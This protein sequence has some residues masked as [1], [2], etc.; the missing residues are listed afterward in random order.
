MHKTIQTSVSFYLENRLIPN[1]DLSTPFMG[2]PGCG[3]TEFL[4]AALPFYLS[5]HLSH[6]YNFSLL[7]NHCARLPQSIESIPVTN[8]L[9]A[10]SVSSF[11]NFDFFV[12]RPRRKLDN[13]FLDLLI[14]LKHDCIAWLHIT[15]EPDYLRALALNPY[16]R[17]IVCVEHEQY[18]SIKDIPN[19]FK[20]TYIVNG[21]D[22][23][24]LRT[25]IHHST[26]TSYTSTDR[27]IVY[28]GAINIQKGFHVL[29]RLWP[30]IHKLYPDLK[31]NVIGSGSLY[32]SSQTLGPLNIAD[33]DYEMQY[34]LPH[35]V[36][37]DGRLMESVNF[38][39]R[40]DHTKYDYMSRASIGVIN[41]TGQTENCPGSALEFQAL[42]VPVV[43]GAYYG[44]L[45]TVRHNHTGLL[46]SNDRKFIANISYLLDNPR[47]AYQFGLNGKDFVSR[48]YSYSRVSLQWDR[49]FKRLQNCEPLPAIPQKRNLYRHYK[50][51]II[52]NSLLQKTI[53][54]IVPWP[55][56]FGIKTTL[57]P[58]LLSLYQSLKL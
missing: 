10:L 2:N 24:H 54:R 20:L 27:N 41:P 19:S 9:D 38:L 56:I 8:L 42:G 35:L 47:Q 22:T 51:L 33:I 34:I 13:Q 5:T 21:F 32:G 45:D 52:L 30:S 3:G 6:Q 37:T 7:A 55:T 16:I 50:F 40:L 25:K 14:N 15:P 53:G 48:R 1:I 29:A 58:F 31:L 23:Q 36:T 43:S 11:R 12:F 44:V 28:L 39:G 46:S 57:F 18:E 49:L 26:F 17:A 4:F